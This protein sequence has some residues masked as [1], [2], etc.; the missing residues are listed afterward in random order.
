MQLD[1]F[2]RFSTIKKFVRRSDAKPIRLIVD[3]GANL[4]ETLLLMHRHFPDARIIGFEPVAEYFESAARRVA[5]IRQIELHNKAVTAQHLFYD[6]LGE[7][8]RPCQM[9]LTLVKALPES[10]SGWR[11]GSLIG[12][13]DHALLAPGISAP[14]YQRIAQ[15]VMPITLAEIFTEYG[16]DG[17]DLLKMDCEGCESS[18]LGCADADVLRRVRFITGEYHALARFYPVTRQRLVPTHKVCFMGSMRLGSFLAERREG[19]ADGLLSHR[20]APV[21]IR[22][23]DGQPIECNAYSET[24]LRSRWRRGL[25]LVGG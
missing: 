17:I 21:A 11:G 5:S 7:R 20:T 3:V 18:V 6:D 4:G 12:P 25:R 16:I 1:P 23:G 10:G 22:G 9:G 8:P 13:D 19:E 24:P 2:Y 14:G 15:P